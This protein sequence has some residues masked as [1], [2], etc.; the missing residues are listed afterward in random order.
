MNASVGPVLNDAWLEIHTM[1]L[2][3]NI[4]VSFEVCII[5]DILMSCVYLIEATLHVYISKEIIL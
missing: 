1:C 3:L 2:H 4:S 5:L